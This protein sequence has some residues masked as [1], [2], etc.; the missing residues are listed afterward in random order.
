MNLPYCTSVASESILSFSIPETPS[1]QRGPS[2]SQRALPYLREDVLNLRGLSQ[3]Q[4]C[5]PPSQKRSL[6]IVREVLL[7]IWGPSCILEGLSQSKRLF[8]ISEDFMSKR[9]RPLS[10]R[11][12]PIFYRAIS[13]SQI[14]LSQHHK[15]TPLSQRELFYLR[16]APPLN[17]R[18]PLLYLK[19][20]LLYV[21]GV[22]PHP[23]T[24]LFSFQERPFAYQRSPFYLRGIFSISQGSLSISE[25][26]FLVS[27]G[28]SSI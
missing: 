22:L 11:W 15:D 19:E 21:R 26:I 2:P 28:P 5:P 23:R 17:H 16:W 18:G 20:A 25:L 3:F 14:G 1:S 12:S 7:H 6:R 13:L 4:R 8:F 10:Q 9:V 27:E 24:A